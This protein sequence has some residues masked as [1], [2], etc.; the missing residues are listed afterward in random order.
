MEN[1]SKSR[2]YV[3][4]GGLKSVAGG[5]RLDIKLNRPWQQDIVVDSANCPF[6]K[7]SNPQNVLG[8]YNGA[9]GTVWRLIQNASTPFKFHGLVVP[10]HCWPK[11][12][13]RRLGGSQKICEAIFIAGNAAMSRSRK[14]FFITVHVGSLGGQNLTHPHYHVIHSIVGDHKSSELFK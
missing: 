7:N 2:F 6:C 10:D 3:W 1:E 12:E 13:L 14:P 4:P 11:E 5:S 9:S 8:T